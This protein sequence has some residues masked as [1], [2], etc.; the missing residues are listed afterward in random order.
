MGL[1]PSSLGTFE[2]IGLQSAMVGVNE[3]ESKIEL[4]PAQ[5]TNVQRSNLRQAMRINALAPVIDIL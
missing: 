1:F 4:L 2:G 3:V 5:G